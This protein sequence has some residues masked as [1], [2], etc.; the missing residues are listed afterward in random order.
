MLGYKFWKKTKFVK[1]EEMDIWS[2]RRE[3]TD[4]ELEVKPKTLW[5]RAK[6]II[7]G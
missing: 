3:Y 1:L 5:Q 2:G 4:E 6:I 7:A